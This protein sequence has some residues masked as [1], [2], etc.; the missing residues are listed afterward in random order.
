MPTTTKEPMINIPIA[1]LTY[2]NK[3]EKSGKAICAIDVELL[4]DANK[5]NMIDMM[6]AEARE[7]YDA[8]KTKGFTSAKELIDHLNS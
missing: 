7:E 6:V 2:L 1:G 3:D 4:T 8:G 5:P